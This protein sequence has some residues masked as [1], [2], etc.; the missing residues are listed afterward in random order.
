M[1]RNAVVFGHVA[2]LST[3][4]GGTLVGTFNPNSRA[5]RAEPAAWLGLSHIAR[6]KTLY[7]EQAA[8]PET[9]IDA[10]LRRDALDFAAAHPGYVATVV[11]HNTLRLFD[12][13]GLARTR[14]GAGTIGLPGTPA[15]AGA[16]MFFA[17][18]VLAVAGAL[19]PAARRVPWVLWLVPALQFASTVIA[20]SETPRFR[21]PIEPFFL[22]LA[23]LACERLGAGAFGRIGRGRPSA[24]E[25]PGRVLVGS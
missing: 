25:R 9:A 18:A 11:W 3:E 23:A 19:R 2:P 14:F 17:V 8:H 1:V 4:S 10:A 24:S 7:R 12:L 5:D 6:Y 20:N 16:L 13:D 15:V 22:L 21:T